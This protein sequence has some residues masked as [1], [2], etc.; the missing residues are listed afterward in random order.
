MRRKN[1]SQSALFGFRMLLALTLCSVGLL[2]AFFAQAGTPGGFN[3][4]MKPQRGALLFAGATNPNAPTTTMTVNSTSPVIANDGFCTLPEAIIAA[5]TR[6]ASGAM[7][8]ECPA[9]SSGGNIIVLQTSATYTLVAPHNASYGPNGLPGV[10][11]PIAIVGNGAIIENQGQVNF[12]LLYISPAGSLSLQNLTLRKGTAKGGDGGA[13]IGGGGGLGAGGAIYNQGGLSLNGVTVTGNAAQGGNGGLGVAGQGAGGAGIGADGGD[14]TGGTPG[15]GGGGGMGGKG[16]PAPTTGGGGGGGANIGEPGNPGA[17]PTGGAG[18][19]TTGGNG[20]NGAPL[21]A[22]NG[23]NAL[24]LGGG[25]GGA[26]NGAAGL[27]SG[28]GAVGG[29]SGGCV[30]AACV[31]GTAGFGGGGGSGGNGTGGN[32]GF[33]GGGGSS[34]GTTPHPGIGGFGGGNGAFD[35]GGGAG[36]GGAIFNDGGSVTLTNSTLTGNTATGGSNGTGLSAA[37]AG[38]ALGGAI[39]NLN[40]S[41]TVNFSTLVNNRVTGGAK[42]A[43]GLGTVGQA[44]GGAVYNHSEGGAPSMSVQNSIIANSV[45][46]ADCNNDAGA[47]LTSSGYNLV[48]TPGATCSFAAPGDLIGT[49]PLLDALSDNGGPTYTHATLPAS[50]AIERI[51]NGVNGCQQ[52]TSVDQRGA[53]RAGGPGKGGNACDT[54]AYEFNSTFGPVPTASP[55]PGTP[56]FFNYQAPSGIGDSAG[57]PS[58][59]SN[60]TKE[61]ISHNHNVNG[62]PDNNIP[63]GGTSLYFGGFLPSMLKITWDDCSSPANP[64]WEDKPLL[65]ASAPRVFGDPILFTDHDTGRTFVCQLEGLTPGGS[66]I[67]ITDDDGDNFIPTDGVIPS[68]VDHET[69]GGGRNHSPLPNPG[70]VYQ[71]AIYYASQSVGDARAFRSDN[72]GLV[73]SQAA[74]PMYTINDCSGL[75]GHI[76]VS[77]ADGTVFVPNRGCGGAI[78]FHDTGARQTLLV[79]EDNGITWAQR[80]IPDS[81]T[82]GNGSADNAILGTHDPSLGVA[83]DGTV[84][85]GY[86]GADGHPRIAVSHNK[87]QTWGPSVDVGAVVVNGGPV[88]NSAFPAVVAGDP[89]RGAFAFF[90]TET[91]GDNW[92]CGQGDDCSANGTGI[93]ARPKF[94][95]VWYLYLATTFDGGVTWTTQNITP[96]DPIQRGGICGGSTCRNLLDFFDATIDKEG[97]ILIGYDDGCI[98]ATCI[99]GDPSI[100]DG[101]GKNDYTARAT[102]ARQSGGK[103]MF[104]AFDP[105]DTTLPGAPILTGRL[106][107]VPAS[108]T[109]AALSWKAPDNGGSD[110][111]GYKI[112]RKTGAAGTFNLIATTP[113]TN[114]T[115]GTLSPGNTYIY[116]VTA[117]NVVGEGPYC[118]DV[119]PI[120]VPN[121]VTPPACIVPGLLAVNDLKADGTDND[122]GQNTPPDSRV[123]VRQLFVAEPCFG[124][125]VNKLVFTMQLAPS[126]AASAPPSS[127][128]YIIWN[129]QN[130]DSNFDRWYVAMKSD[131]NG[132]VSFE[133]GKFG[134]PLDPNNPNPNA[135]TPSRL[136]DADTGTYNVATGEVRITLSTSKAENVGVGGSLSGLN[137]RNYL[138]RPDAGQKSQNNASDI[139]VDGNYV[140]QGSTGCCGPV[141]LLGVASRKTHGSVGTFDVP[142]PLTGNPGIECRSGGA[143]SDYQIV[144]TFANPIASVSGASITS[145]SGS[146]NN[147][148][149]GAEPHE[150]I[151]NLT[152]VSNAQRVTVTL[153]TVR[154]TAGDR[155]DTLPVIIGVLLGDT[156]ANGFVNS[157]DVSQTQSQ[158]GQ[159][160]TGANFR[161]DVTANGFINSADVSIVQ[162][163]SG[164]SLP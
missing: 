67:D 61:T 121:P 16:G 13:G 147:S 79:S 82:H 156:T 140:L 65:G 19:G 23:G 139:T 138:A 132:V 45:G 86:Q 56:R 130:P 22:T 154:D 28:N 83:T 27:K 84:Y 133:Y 53:P 68:D 80:P 36:M 125:G 47:T 88:L 99:N 3:R 54:G 72:G 89:N 104:G 43:G 26:G 10:T 52:G 105:P 57:E 98:T 159:P 112:Y 21:V 6:T 62:S 91:P 44:R 97:R 153:T 144:F 71:N 24:G 102:I 15:G 126:T 96:G 131:P 160:V 110:I 120:F 59:G 8:G 162:S 109:S 14:S 48:K 146:I 92:P 114:Y 69:I 66:T 143:N 38:D 41:V 42:G 49:D 40:G 5:N 7:A 58:I 101:G 122:S 87:G 155:T 76:K 20:G 123:N 50:Q 142:L 17:G 60:W 150:Y 93:N 34:G 103:H 113:V 1:T 137:V 33:G 117:V 106:N 90:G 31:A 55:P 136:G 35:G 9:G 141:P 94:T 145:G 164:T 25:G 128:W 29:G 30:N 124:P 129:R 161:Q 95:G 115:D 127:Q 39:F 64:L 73:F 32:G 51:P 74:S 157:G 108:A 2:L 148:A 85:F 77:P 100:T 12:R 119:T 37:V 163:K 158:S 149:V 63:N 81:T 18:G 152:G 151:V 78:P 116:H 111:T 135:N 70:P 11:S 75:H 4:K 46:A 134:V 107:D 118:S